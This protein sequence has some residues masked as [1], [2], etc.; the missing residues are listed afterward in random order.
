VG[1]VQG[2]VNS[3][4]LGWV[5]QT[6][7]A[8]ASASLGRSPTP[9]GIDCCSVSALQAPCVSSRGAS[10]GALCWG[11]ADAVLGVAG[12]E[13]ASWL[14]AMVGFPTEKVENRKN[15]RARS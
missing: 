12:R 9:M 2:S 15:E 10:Y 13:G 4:V 7:Q 5:R 6:G 14:L 11:G 8:V 1:L 3:F